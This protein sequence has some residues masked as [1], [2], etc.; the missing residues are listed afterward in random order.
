MKLIT[1]QLASVRKFEQLT[2]N[3]STNHLE[4]V[5]K[6]PHPL[7]LVIASIKA[8]HGFNEENGATSVKDTKENIN[9]FEIYYVLNEE[10]SM[11]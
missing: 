6:N 2:D 5:L 10:D 7:T 8:M 1:V 3:Y 4:N 9:K 11:F